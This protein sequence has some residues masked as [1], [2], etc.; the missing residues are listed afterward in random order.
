MR[1]GAYPCS[2]HSRQLCVYSRL[3]SRTIS[4]PNSGQMPPSTASTVCSHKDLL[5]TQHKWQLRDVKLGRWVV[6]WMGLLFRNYRGSLAISYKTCFQMHTS[7]KTAVFLE[8][9]GTSRLVVGWGL[10]LCR[11][12]GPSL[13]ITRDSLSRT[14][15]HS[16]GWWPSPSHR[17][18]DGSSAAGIM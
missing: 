14:F 13:G 15:Y 8:A 16:D 12:R 3:T 9:C 4:H 1:A 18:P 10:C 2:R 11:S 5:V 6:H 7:I 17:V